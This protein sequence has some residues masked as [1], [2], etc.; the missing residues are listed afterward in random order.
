MKETLPIHE[1]LTKQHGGSPGVRYT[2]LDRLH[3][4]QP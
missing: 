1:A 3:L 2:G 4:F